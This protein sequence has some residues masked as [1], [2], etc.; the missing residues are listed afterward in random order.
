M[1]LKLYFCKKSEFEFKAFASIDV[2]EFLV[3]QLKTSPLPSLYK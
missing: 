1:V 3:V 2:F